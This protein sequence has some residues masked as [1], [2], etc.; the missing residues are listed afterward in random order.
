MK[1]DTTRWWHVS[2]RP[3]HENLETLDGDGKPP[4]D[5][6]IP[7]MG[8]DGES[9][10]W[11]YAEDEEE[12]TGKPFR[13]WL[14]LIVLV[15]AAGVIA[16]VW[17]WHRQ[18]IE[19]DP[20]A[21]VSE[22][23]MG[24]IEAQL[25]EILPP[26]QIGEDPTQR[27]LPAGLV[28]QTKYL[29]THGSEE[30]NALAKIALK[31][32]DGADLL[33]NT[34][35][36][37]PVALVF[38]LL[39]LQGHNWYNVGEFDRAVKSY[40]QALMLQPENAEALSNAAIAHTQAKQGDAITHWRRAVELLKQGV[41][42]APGGSAQW[43][44][45]QNNLGLALAESLD[46]DRDDN[47]KQAVGA[48]R[49]AQTKL[50]CDGD[51]ALWAKLQNN[52]GTVWLKM[53]GGDQAHNLRNAIT[54]FQSALDVYNRKDD[55][56]E[57]ATAQHNL[58]EAWLALAGQPVGNAEESLAHAAAAFRLAV[59]TLNRDE[60]PL[61]WAK[62]Q[63]N[64]GLTLDRLPTGDLAEN[65]RQA[66]AAFQAAERVYSRSLHP[67]EW[68]SNRFN[69]ALALKHLADTAAKGC[70]Q[71][72]QSMAYLKAATGVWMPEN[73]PPFPHQSQVAPLTQALREAWRSHGCGTE[74]ALEDIPAAK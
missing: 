17:V 44:K 30:Q 58:G 62:T 48:L 49:S 61:E 21:P 69:Q 56:L 5:G 40:E 38:R 43:C 13:F 46:G 8:D 7:K 53:G 39:T 74:K 10:Q 54:A 29:L 15:L 27:Q 37:E 2:L 14:L 31:N 66:I 20:Q 70:G 25:R 72:W 52:L 9:P 50:A 60:Y 32:D 42:Q 65:R 33:I 64:I 26:G 55:P 35:K 71:L 73:A 16:I 4:T 1:S 34:L 68:A 63:D 28:G 23:N 59:E 67:V 19:T 47:L 3:K 24:L 11:Y 18:T 57:W 22:G 51:Q 6:A 36:R 45:L 12:S 41:A